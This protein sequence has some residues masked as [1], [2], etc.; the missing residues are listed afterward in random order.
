MHR[1]PWNVARAICHAEGGQLA[2]IRSQHEENVLVRMFNDPDKLW[3]G[4]STFAYLGFHDYY[5]FRTF[6]TING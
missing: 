1:R 4:S 6:Y 5:R 2:I 3:P